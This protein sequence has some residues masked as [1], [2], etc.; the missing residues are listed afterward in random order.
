[1]NSRAAVPP[2][3]AHVV[4]S[5][6]VL[7]EG[8]GEM[9]DGRD[10]RQL[11]ADREAQAEG[12]GQARGPVDQLHGIADAPQRLVEGLVLLGVQLLLPDEAVGVA[13]QRRIEVL[14]VAADDFDDELLAGRDGC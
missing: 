10:H 3:E 13:S 11:Q 8:G 12:L 4:G 1:M 5:Q 9:F 14:P 6:D 7:G 2:R